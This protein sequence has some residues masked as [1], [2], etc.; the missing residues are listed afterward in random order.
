MAD[1]QQVIA[2]RY[3]EAGREVLAL[4]RDRPPGQRVWR[5]TPE[6]DNNFRVVWPLA[7]HAINQAATGMRLV[8]LELFY[9][10][11]AIARVALEHAVIAQWVRVTEDGPQRL[12]ATMTGEHDKTVSDLA[13][14]VERDQ[15][16]VELHEAADRQRDLGRQAPNFAQICEHF[17]GKQRT[18]YSIYRNLNGAVHPSLATMNAYLDIDRVSGAV[19]LSPVPLVDTLPLDLAMTLGWSALLAAYAVEALAE[20]S[21]SR[22]Q[23]VVDIATRAE[24]PV[25]L[26]L[27]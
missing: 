17:T 16:P 12:V 26:T 7:M 15:I 27:G 20:G 9:P 4:Y 13:T 8:D 2:E 23:D 6:R 19:S 3:L 21:T 18:I 24:M 5:V 11:C 14:F 10:A 25:D 1:N 22:C